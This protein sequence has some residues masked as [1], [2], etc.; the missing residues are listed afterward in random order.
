MPDKSP[1]L[2][3]LVSGI[4]GGKSTVA[5][6]LGE[7]GAH[8]IDADKQAHQQL[9]HP[10]VVRQLVARWGSDVVDTLGQPDR[11]AIAARIF[12]P[13]E[14]AKQER[15]WIES[16]LHP[17]VRRRMDEII[18]AESSSGQRVFVVDVPLLVEVGWHELCDHVVWIETPLAM[19][20]QNAAAR[21]W[22]AS[23]L[24]Q[25]EA[26][27]LDCG[28]KQAAASRTI[29]NDGSLDDLRNQVREF[30]QDSIDPR[31][32]SCT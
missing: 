30:W 4:A 19:R 1:I 25:R 31:E 6:M 17:R 13:D 22:A 14:Y 26:A 24:A 2:I 8:V 5:R 18:A 32:P 15:E 23:E 9:A 21:G 10:E 7:L 16:I 11:A 29:R 3:G 20:E 12:G 28:K 27:Q